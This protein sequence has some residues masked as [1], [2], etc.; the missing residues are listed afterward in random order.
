MQQTNQMRLHCITG[1][2]INFTIAH[3]SEGADNHRMNY[4]F[5]SRS[6][7]IDILFQYILLYII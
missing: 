3:I 7:Y 1:E 6:I 2:R 5:L 4:F